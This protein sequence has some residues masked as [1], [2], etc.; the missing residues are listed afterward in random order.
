MTGLH[1]ADVRSRAAAVARQVAERLAAP[2]DVAEHARRAELTGRR[3]WAPGT[4]HAGHPGIAALHATLDRPG[5]A[6]AHLAAAGRSAPT[7]ATVQA[8]LPAALLHRTAHGGYDR[9]VRQAEAATLSA[10]RTALRAARPEPGLSMTEYDAVTGLSAIG[11]LLL[12][13]VAD[14]AADPAVPTVLAEVLQRLVGISEPV[15][16]HGAPVPGWWCSPDRYALDADRERYPLGDLNAGL[17]HGVAGPLA[18]LALARLRGHEVPGGPAAIARIAAWLVRW[19]EAGEHGPTW[20]GRVDLRVETGERPPPPPGGRAAWCYGTAGVARALQLAGAA[21]DD[22][23]LSGTALDAIRGVLAGGPERA[24][25]T[26]LS[27]C[28]GE[29]GLLLIARRM[30]G[31]D[32]AIDALAARLLDRFDP[33]SAFGFR[34][35]NPVSDEPGLLYGATG[36]AL[37]LADLADPPPAERFSWD[38]VLL[39]S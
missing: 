28:H 6:R 4:L 8:L 10:A 23:A 27:L 25:L 22:D 38:A 36:I 33:A 32:P 14:P 15:V 1:M 30:L 31:D 13:L 5:R 16:V 18:L 29:A 37:A 11:R 9:L 19:Q 34:H 17:A 3:T 7:P 26:D 12:E 24:G 39:L 35:G 21:L 20:P 2:E